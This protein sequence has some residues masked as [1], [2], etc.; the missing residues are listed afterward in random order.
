MDDDASDTSL[1]LHRRPSILVVDDDPNVGA[2]VARTMAHMPVDC[3]VAEDGESFRRRYKEKQHDLVVLDM[4]LPDTDG[5]ELLR[6]IGAQTHRTRILI[7]SGRDARLIKAAANLARAL[8][9]DVVA[10]MQKPL[11]VKRLRSWIEQGLGERTP[12]VP[13]G[14]PFGDLHRAIETD[15]LRVFYQPK[16][17]VRTGRLAGA[18]A[19]IRWQHPQ[20][21]LVGAMEFVPLAERSG[22]IVPMTR[23]VIGEVARQ[24][25]EWQLAGLQF[26]VS[27]NVPAA[28]LNDIEF[29]GTVM[30]LLN[31]HGVPGSSLCIEITESGATQDIVTATDVL[32]RL[33][34]QGIALSI[35]DFGTGYSSLMKLHQL[36]FTELKIDKA[37]VI[38]LDS[39]E[40][41][42]VIAQTIISL[43][44]SLHMTV[45]AEGVETERLWHWLEYMNCDLAQ[46]YLIGKPMDSGAFAVWIEAW[47][48]RRD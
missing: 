8:G 37:F 12:D 13:V 27:V 46:G 20:R 21:G 25:A 1:S 38:D 29:P 10:H 2:I 14:S 32:T 18:E 47:D 3:V 24:V 26:P 22:L 34:I 33:R 17:E 35:D 42:R 5:I 11:A 28:C 36:P 45:T 16:V 23:W 40:D 48:N 43:A 9:L 44:R 41:S 6:Y 19:L 31:R 7:V 39:N 30:E 15:E 4:H